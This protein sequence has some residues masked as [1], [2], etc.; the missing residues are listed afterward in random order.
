[1][2]NKMDKGFTLIELMIVVAIIGILTAIALPAYQD[3]ITK[4]KWAGIVTEVSPLKKSIV[5][6]LQ[7]NNSNGT[8]CD[9]AIE[10]VNY[11]TSSSPVLTNTSSAA[12]I[13]NGAIGGVVQ[14]SIVGNSNISS[15]PN[16]PD[17][18][19]YT[20]QLDTSRSK[21]IWSQSGT[22]PSKFVK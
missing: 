18:L 16:T 1:M 21:Y 20:S 2:K 15:N 9:S 11:G 13:S 12:A 5:F 3:Y 14:I 10:L 8:R 4:T 7:D 22:V 6:C 19:I 17:T